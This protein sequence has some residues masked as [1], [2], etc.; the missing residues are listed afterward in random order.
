MLSAPWLWVYWQRTAMNAESRLTS[1]TRW[2]GNKG[3]EK[4][5]EFFRDKRQSTFF[6]PLWTRCRITNLIVFPVFRCWCSFVFRKKIIKSALT[7]HVCDSKKRIITY[8]HR[9]TYTV[10]HTQFPHE[11]LTYQKKTCSLKHYSLKT[12]ILS[13]NQ[14]RDP[15]LLGKGCKG[16]IL[17]QDKPLT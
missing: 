11:Q 12:I 17:L 8:I 5:T 10:S 14:G 9:Q 1:V 16:S 2:V 3:S 13:F 4:S 7:S 6:L 15:S